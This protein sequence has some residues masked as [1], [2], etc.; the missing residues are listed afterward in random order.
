MMEDKIEEIAAVLR[1][2]DSMAEG[3]AERVQERLGQ[4]VSYDEI[5][6]VLERISPPRITMDRVVSKLRSQLHLE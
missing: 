4:P 5:L 6:A 2:T 1:S 3:F